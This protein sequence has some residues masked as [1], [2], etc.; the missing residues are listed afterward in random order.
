MLLC[1]W[2]SLLTLQVCYFL[3]PATTNSNLG[4]LQNEDIL[5]ILDTLD[6]VSDFREERKLMGKVL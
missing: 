1:A 3:R 6:K 2:R 5:D 4:F